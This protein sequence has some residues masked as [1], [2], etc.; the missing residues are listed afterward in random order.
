MVRVGWR[1]W[2]AL[3]LDLLIASG[4]LAILL[5]VLGLEA[6]RWP[7]SLAVVVA[8]EAF[9][10]NRIRGSF[11]HFAMGL[12]LGAD[13]EWRADPRLIPPTH[14]LL[15][16]VGMIHFLNA[17]RLYTDGLLDYDAYHVFGWPV[18]GPVAKV[19]L[20]AAALGFV[21]S[22]TALFRRPAYGPLVALGVPVLFLLND[23]T[24]VP[25]LP[26]TMSAAM[27]RAQA[28]HGGRTLPL[29]AEDWTQVLLAVQLLHLLVLFV[30]LA[31]FRRHF[32]PR[33]MRSA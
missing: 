32:P 30:V 7:I 13:G 31:V 21:A 24:S 1:R 25:L 14:W 33:R 27:E 18:G 10:W 9:V 15:L 6:Y 11:G 17:Y 8:L 23:S 12:T 26:A 19:V 5:R 3:Y 2:G 20:V 4:A 29:D 28:R 16:L 22:A